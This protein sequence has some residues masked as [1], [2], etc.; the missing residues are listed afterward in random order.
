MLV[1]LPRK[2][3][4]ETGGDDLFLILVDAENA[5]KPVDDRVPI[6]RVD[7]LAAHLS[8][9]RRQ[10]VRQRRDLCQLIGSSRHTESPTAASG[11]PAARLRPPRGPSCGSPRS[12]RRSS[13]CAGSS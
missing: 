7:P 9:E 8:A 11:S 2:I 5:R 6:V 12:R 4:V 13:S 1:V 10:N 3:L